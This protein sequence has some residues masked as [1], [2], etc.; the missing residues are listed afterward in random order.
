VS[1]SLSKIPGRR[2]LWLLPVALYV[3]LRLPA[4]LR[5]PAFADEARFARWAQLIAGDHSRLFV[6][7]TAS[8]KQFL[9][10]WLGALLSRAVGD[11]LLADRL[12]SVTCGLLSLL[13]V[14]T[15]LRRLAEPDRPELPLV[16]GLLYAA[17]PF[18]VFHERLGIYE[19]LINL[20][21]L[22][23]FWSAWRFWEQEGRHAAWPLGLVWGLGLIT[24]KYC[25]VFLAYPIIVRLALWLGGRRPRV[26]KAGRRLLGAAVLALAIFAAVN[27]Y[28]RLVFHDQ[29]SRVTGDYLAGDRVQLLEALMEN[30]GHVGEIAAV[31]LGWPLLALCG[32]GFALAL[33]RRRPAWLAMAGV[34][35]AVM[36][37][38]TALSLLL[39]ARYL[40][41]AVPFA[42]LLAAWVIGEAAARLPV[43]RRIPRGM[44]T[45][46]CLAVVM[47]VA[48]PR[49]VAIVRDPTTAPLASRDRW[50][51]VTGWPSGYGVA[52][53]AAY[54]LGQAE[55]G[56]IDVFFQYTILGVPLNGLEVRLANDP[57]IRFHTADW[58]MQKPLLYFV[59]DGEPIESYAGNHDA[60]RET[61]VP[62]ALTDVYF[63]ANVPFMDY[64]RFKQLNPP[65]ETQRIFY[66]PG[67][68]SALVVLKMSRT[69]AP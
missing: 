55:A 37:L 8:G 60:G 38:Q 5:L 4:L 49:S 1:D 10:P 12:L 58:V 14:M 28:P 47:A 9:Y 53:A 33:W 48:L 67:A 27:V 69:A 66:R 54:L 2:L 24:K 50:Q 35:L 44:V 63:V 25:L 17:T 23:A 31:Y 11:P 46:V 68:Q 40:M 32:L 15:M 18:L 42:V 56:P 57:R 41:I 3:G 13:L 62:A 59:A 29:A 6:P 21:N 22:A 64:E 65:P 43:G 30:P 34:G 7:Y 19:P 16:G 45:L 61:I 36:L 51:H 26:E 39:Y 20:L 52:E